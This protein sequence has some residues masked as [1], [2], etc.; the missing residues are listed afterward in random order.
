[1]C[2]A[3]EGAREKKKGAVRMGLWVQLSRGVSVVTVLCGGAVA[4]W[5]VGA[6]LLPA[7]AF[8][9]SVSAPEVSSQSLNSIVVE[10]NRRVDANTVRNY[11]RTNPGE[12]LD[13]IKIDEAW[14]A[15]LATGL[16]ED[17][18]IR[19]S[20][21]RIVVTVIEAAVLNRVQFEGNRVVKDE[22][23]STEVQSK[24]R[25][26]LSRQTV[27]ND[28]QRILDIYRGNGRYDVR[29]EP[30]IIDLSNGRVDL[31][32]EVT[33]GKKTTVR[34]ITFAGNRN[35]SS[36][37]LK[38]VIKTGE[39]GIM[40]FFKSNDVYDA[41]KIEQDKDLLRR[42]Y[43]KNGYADVR[44]VSAVSEYDPARRGFSVV[45]NIDEG[46]YYRF[47]AIDV[48][49][50]V[51]EIDPARLRRL[52]KTG[53][54]N[55]YNAEAVEKSV[56]AMTVE[57]ARS[58]YPFAQVRPRGDRDFQSHTVGLVFVVD[59]GAR[60][61]IERI[62]VRGN[63]RTRDYVIRREFDIGEGDPYNHALIE[64]AER[65]LKNLG[66]FKNV[67]ITSDAGSAPDRVIVNVE[68]EETSTGEFSV[69]G[70]YSTSD[71][72][73]AEVSVAERNLLGRGQ[74]ARA[75]VSYGQRARGFELSF[76][77]PYLLG[78]R[79]AFG[80]DVFSK[81]MLAS[82]YQSYDSTTR[83]GGFRFGV[84][85]TEELSTQLRYQVYSQEISIGSVYNCFPAS[86]GVLQPDGTI[87]GQC[88]PAAPSLREAANAGSVITSLIGYTLVYNTLDNVRSPTKGLI[89]EFKQD[90]AGVGGD[91]NFIRTT[92]DARFYYDVGWDITAMFRA[93]GG[94][95]MGWGGKDLRMLD[96]FFM[97]PNLVRG[98]APAGLGPRDVTPDSTFDAL[99][100]TMYWGVTAELQYP[101][102]FAP[103][104]FGM[105]LAV[106]ADA[107]SV[108]G[109][110]GLTS[111]QGPNDLVA[112][113]IAPRDVNKIRS[114]V[115]VGLIWD[116]PFGPLRFEYAYALTKDD[117]VTVMSNGVPVQ[118][119]DRVQQ[120]RFSGGTKF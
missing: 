90:F 111:Y 115:G 21:G 51:R 46:D 54:G 60:G 48:Q 99:G 75:A 95:V 80:V 69:A 3:L 102:I 59:Q 16:F 77:E 79:V 41:D 25:G 24:P 103:K 72:F 13:A 18:Q 91:V 76:V 61:Y 39:T 38:D 28:V 2:G 12:R 89:A 110:K 57:L 44:I 71:G 116:S 52:L 94:H 58:G 93:Q 9:Q 78:Y 105:K 26:P 19:Q 31:V 49:S 14:K 17:V 65:R 106:F 74:M 10:G 62:N 11:F 112:Q 56:E 22:Q 53:S 85:I 100:G 97:G 43:L 88:I 8:A 86:P 30:K 42:F 101:L 23:L 37:R 63:S 20:G 117:G 109:Y 35:Y 40:S 32:F 113:T 64:R 5:S 119:G 68:V 45:F 4:A 1:M 114:S 96:H 34:S 118:V 107:G 98:F 47:G 27:R 29:V 108:W 83:G 50:N 81:T 66:F 82:S 36:S 15:L 87:V 55:V 6:V 104:D 70:G 7:S 84:P 120:F 73:I 67:R 33:E 92:A